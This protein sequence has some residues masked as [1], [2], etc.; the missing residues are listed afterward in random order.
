MFPI[1]LVP[2]P[3]STAITSA[4]PV[5]TTTF[6]TA[7]GI[8]LTCTVMLAPEVAA[9][10][11]QLYVIVNWD[12]HSH[13]IVMNIN[14]TKSSDSNLQFVSIL[15]ISSVGLFNC[16][17]IVNSSSPYLHASGVKSDTITVGKMDASYI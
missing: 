6:S 15:P 1:S 13:P 16:K 9:F 5:N 10:L 17:A 7:V 4:D 3:V 14:A 11:L 2:D 8:N 12:R